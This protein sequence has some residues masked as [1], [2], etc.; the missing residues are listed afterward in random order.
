MICRPLRNGVLFFYG[1]HVEIR[2]KLTSY[3]QAV[4]P[5]VVGCYHGCYLASKGLQGRKDHIADPHWWSFMYHE[6]A[7]RLGDEK[8]AA[9]FEALGRWKVM[10]TCFSFCCE[11]L[12]PLWIFV[13][14]GGSR[15]DLEQ[16]SSSLL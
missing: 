9:Y 14:S 15:N 1:M 6:L 8:V 10:E 2:P 16:Y 5:P 11:I 7:A 3:P 4:Y 12:L 13:G